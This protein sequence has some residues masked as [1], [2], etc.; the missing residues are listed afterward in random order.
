MA[1]ARAGFKVKA[2]C[3]SGHPL[4]KTGA[5]DEIYTYHGMA[6]LA[7]FAS[8]IAKARPE[9]VIPGDDL[10]TRQLHEVYE[11]NQRAGKAGE[12]TCALIERSLGN[13]E[14]FPLVYAR[15]RFIALA[16]KEGV[17]VPKTEVVPDL[18]A[19]RTWVGKN[20]LPAVLKSDGSSGGDGVQVARTPEESEA[21]FGRLS[22]PPNWMRTVKRA[23][24]DGDMTLVW[25]TMLRRRPAVNAQTFVPGREATSAVACWR[26]SVLAAL[27][28]DVIT[29]A[30]SRGPATVLRLIEDAEMSGAA[31]KMVCKL[32]LSGFYGFDF[33]RETQ[34]GSAYL[35]EINP[36]TTQVGHLALGAGRNLPAAL[37]AAVSGQ[38]VEATPMVTN[39]DTIALFPQEWIRDSASPYL[40]TA[41]HDVPWDA[42]ELVMACVARYRHQK[43]WYAPKSERKVGGKLVATAHDGLPEGPAPSSW[44]TKRS[45]SRFP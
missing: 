38:P 35:I 27:H 26:G 28:F 37:Y 34:T 2:L 7:S 5:A 9:I 16:E 32:N 40:H 22:A 25:P 23:V 8:A 21:A 30:E 45:K 31:E 1:L 24:F 29:T 44:A 13:G 3:P 17:R 12:A 11:R 15:A 4:L 10:A 14:S 43:N 18:P 33:V 39:K 6:P 19:L 42:P 20:G 36:R 41:Y